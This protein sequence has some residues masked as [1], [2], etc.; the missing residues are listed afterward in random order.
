MTRPVT[1]YV[2]DE[3]GEPVRR[4]L[5]DHEFPTQI[6]VFCDECGKRVTGDYV[7]NEEMSKPER[8]EV[9]RAHLRREDWQCDK[10]GD[11]CPDCKAADAQ[12]MASCGHPTVGDPSDPLCGACR[13]ESDHVSAEAA[14]EAGR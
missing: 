14:R 1:V 6:T 9:A 3:S 5:E 12:R 8:L 4:V 2:H 11:Y 10:T 13:N 7:I